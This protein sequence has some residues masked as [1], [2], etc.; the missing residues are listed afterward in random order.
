MTSLDDRRRRPALMA[1]ITGADGA[2]QG[3]QATLLA[4]HGEA[5]ANVETPRRVIGELLGGEV[6]LADAA[7][8]LAIGEGVETMLSASFSL[9]LPAWAALTAYNLS[10]F[11]PPP[12]VSEL[13]VAAD[14]DAAG[15]AAADS[16]RQRLAIRV[17]LRLPQ[18]A[19]RIGMTGRA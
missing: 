4:S 7:N 9:G 17:T 1:A 12:Q 13:V 16:L 11:T 18:M 3:V 5:K 2:L 14:N 10:L 15:L 19:R 6:R 8:V